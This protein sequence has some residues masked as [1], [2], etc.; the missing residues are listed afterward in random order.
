MRIVILVG[1]TL[2]GAG[3]SW[4]RDA[5]PEQKITPGARLIYMGGRPIWTICSRGDR[6]YLTDTGQFQVV[7]GAC[8]S[9]EP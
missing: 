2:V 7:A 5:P 9:G 4:F 8:P 1:L 6:V 3:C